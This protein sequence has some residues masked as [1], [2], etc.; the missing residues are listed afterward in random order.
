LVF[1]FDPGT[2]GRRSVQATATVGEGGRV[3]LPEPI[4]VR[5]GEGCVAV[6]ER[7]S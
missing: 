6:P 7:A 2:G 1:K 4:L 5:A 3:D